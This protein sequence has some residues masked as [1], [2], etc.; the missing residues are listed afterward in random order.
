MAEARWFASS[1]A[2]NATFVFTEPSTGDD[3]LFNEELHT[4]LTL[5]MQLAKKNRSNR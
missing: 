4:F 1:N 3:L 2:P 5:H